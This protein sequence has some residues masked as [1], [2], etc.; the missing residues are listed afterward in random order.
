MRQNLTGEKALRYGKGHTAQSR[1]KMSETKKAQQ[2]RGPLSHT[3]KGGRYQTR[4]GYIMVSLH[5]L[6]EQ[7][8]TLFAPMAVVS[9]G[10]YL[11]EHRLVVARQVGRALLPEESVHHRNG[12]KDDNR[13]ENLELHTAESHRLLHAQVDRELCELRRENEVLRDALSKYC[14][15]TSLLAG[16]TTSS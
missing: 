6:P 9:Q 7:E 11:P 8:Q 2:R 10:R 15:V 16:S 1:Q 3:W 4:L 14:D 12:I 5:T 13:P